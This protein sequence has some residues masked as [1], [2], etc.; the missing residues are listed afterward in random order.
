MSGCLHFLFVSTRGLTSALS[1]ASG[2]PVKYVLVW[3]SCAKTMPEMDVS[4]IMAYT[5]IIFDLF[6]TSIIP[7]SVTDIFNNR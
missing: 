5:W 3:S 7:I 6:W 4:V 2:G 1:V